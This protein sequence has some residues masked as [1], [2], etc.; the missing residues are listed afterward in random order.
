MPERKRRR[1]GYAILSAV[2]AAAFVLAFCLSC[3]ANSVDEANEPDA[4]FDN[5]STEPVLRI[6][7]WETGEVYIEHA[8]MPGDELYF[9]WIHSLEKFPWDE[10]YHIDEELNLIL[11]TIRFPA[12]GAGIPENKG[13][14]CYVKDGLIYM[15]GI[16][17]KFTEFVWMN[18]HTATQEIRVADEFVTRGSDLPR[19]RLVLNISRR[20]PNG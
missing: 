9:G 20:N 10:Y 19:K 5:V 16:N 3:F 11:D 12:F 14:V 18:S 15:S 4:Y 17:Q 8:V 7:D 6:T 2:C 13:A 1:T